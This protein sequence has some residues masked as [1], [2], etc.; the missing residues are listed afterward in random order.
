MKEE[1]R[2]Y[3][4][5]NAVL[6]GGQA[7]QKAVISK[8]LGQ[9]PDLRKKAKDIIPEVINI[10]N[11][12]NSM[13][14]EEQR[15]IVEE[16]DPEFFVSEKK[17]K[18]EKKGLP[19][20]PDAEEGKVVTRMPPEPNGYP[21]IGHGM[22]FYFN[23][24]YAREYGGKVILRFDD[25]NPKAEQREFYDAI[26]DDLRW[27]GLSWEREHNMSDDM[28]KYYDYA[29]GLIRSGNAYM[30]GCEPEK[31]SKLRYDKKTCECQQNSVEENMGLW[32]SMP[33]AEEGSLALRLRGD[34][35]SQNTAM[36]D[37]TLF[38]I[39]RH[40]HPIQGDRYSVWP[41]YDFACSIEDSILGV[42]HVLRSNEF[43][44]RIELQD[45]IRELL[46][47]RC[48]ITIQYSRFT[49]RGTPTSK[50]LIKPLILDRTVSGWDDPRL[51]TVRGLRRRGIVPETIQELA[52][53]M[54]LSTAEPEI[55]WSLIESINRKLID[56]VSKR[57]FFVEDPV[58]VDVSG[59]K[60]CEVELRMH[61]VE[62]LGTRRIKVGEKV[63][64]SSSDASGLEDG[65]LVRLKDLCNIRVT[66][67]EGEKIRSD[68]IEDDIDIR[69]LKKIQW[70]SEDFVLV[71]VLMS[72]SL[73]KDK[74]LNPESLSINLGLGEASLDSLDIGE[75]V[76]FERY[77]FVRIDSKDESGI[78]V[79]FS[80]K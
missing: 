53:E 20:L 27:M 25:T 50:R 5:K 29:V 32:E 61:P 16:M 26:K 1:V 70:V 49:I 74:E 46:Q 7:Q 73:Y 38:R 21:H 18:K 39:I 8:L 10:I 44:L 43:A 31:V 42:T 23:Y 67:R 41:V 4:L 59:L 75:I 77:G 37:P 71:S 47:L 40:P 64:I 62:D 2:E 65:G 52:K 78:G 6:H 45:Y 60:P 13:D 11:E 22:S 33:D 15:R 54:G 63:Y 17:E 30:C 24:Y 57:F 69:S 79:V 58:E 68:I 66:G 35:S 76:Q 55:D 3:A 51:V 9:N 12:V 56:P 48:P 34:V 80:H 72:H 14:P 28:E 36:R 19:P